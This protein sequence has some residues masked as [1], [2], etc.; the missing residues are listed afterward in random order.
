MAS[1]KQL[2]VTVRVA[3]VATDDVTPI[4]TFY[5][6]STDGTTWANATQPTW[7]LLAAGTGTFVCT[8]V[9]VADTAIEYVIDCGAAADDRYLEGGF[10][11]EDFNADV[12]SSLL[13]TAAT[14]TAIK[15]KTDLISPANSTAITSTLT[16]S[17]VAGPSLSLPQGQPW[18][19]TIT[20]LDAE[21][22]ALD[23][24]GKTVRLTFLRGSGSG[25]TTELFTA[26]G[27][28]RSPATLGIADVEIDEA[29]TASLGVGQGY[30]YTAKAIDDS[31]DEV[32]WIFTVS[33]AKIT[34]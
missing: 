31:D 22:E 15:A 6:S 28:N 9:P 32:T 8:V 29:D 5:K 17:G 3:G 13:A 11:F 20:A 25:A 21:G 33:P 24:T 26:D 1:P 16:G 23:L 10:R 14:A 4:W 12:A 2:R 19:V 18:T 27:V 30:L 34:P 7:V